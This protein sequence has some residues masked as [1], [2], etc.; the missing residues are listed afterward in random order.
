MLTFVYPYI[1]VL[2]C[3]LSQICNMKAS[4][5]PAIWGHVLS[6]RAIFLA[7]D[8]TSICCYEELMTYLQSY[9]HFHYY[10]KI[11]RNGSLWLSFYIPIYY[12]TLF[13][14][15]ITILFL[16]LA[17]ILLT[18]AVW[19]FPNI[20]SI[21]TSLWQCILTRNDLLSYWKNTFSTCSVQCTNTLYVHMLHGNEFV[22]THIQ[23]FYM[24]RKRE[25]ISVIKFPKIT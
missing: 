13:V 4:A 6:T 2:N 25:E 20:V 10:A 21:R 3:A 19:S 17:W 9:V 5:I 7:H 16:F 1:M 11:I 12:I 8:T 23:I 24:L 18:Q 15:C 14:S 22:H